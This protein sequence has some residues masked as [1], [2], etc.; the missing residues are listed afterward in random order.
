[1]FVLGGLGGFFGALSVVLIGLLILS[2]FTE[3]L[4]STGYGARVVNKSK[5]NLRLMKFNFKECSIY[6]KCGHIK[7]LDHKREEVGEFSRSKIPL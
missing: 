1:M 2:L 7:L 5:H 6:P 4:L 3:H